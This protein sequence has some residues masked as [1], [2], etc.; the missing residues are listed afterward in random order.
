MEA[1]HHIHENH[2]GKYPA[3]MLEPIELYTLTAI[4]LC[5]VCSNSKTSI[6]KLNTYRISDLYQTSVTLCGRAVFIAE[7]GFEVN[8]EPLKQVLTKH[9]VTNAHISAVYNVQFRHC[10][11]VFRILGSC[12]K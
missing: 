2:H 9:S 10:C 4:I 5:K 8:Q 7:R 3:Y 11:T 6:I 1:V 12:K